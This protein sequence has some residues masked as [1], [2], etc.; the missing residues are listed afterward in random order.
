MGWEG[1]LLFYDVR[2]VNG[3]AAPVN[4]D[5]TIIIIHNITLK[6]IIMSCM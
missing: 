2:R 5:N 6:L 1:R 4:M 3:V